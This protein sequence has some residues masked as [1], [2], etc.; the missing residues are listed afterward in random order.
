MTATDGLDDFE[1]LNQ[2]AMLGAI[3]EI[4][5]LAAQLNADAPFPMTCMSRARE[6]ASWA[7]HLASLA[8]QQSGY[9]E[10]RR[11]RGELW[12]GADDR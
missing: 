7:C 1:R 11:V 9:R 6:I 2:A 8:G 12:R 10:A 5:K 4:K 3:D